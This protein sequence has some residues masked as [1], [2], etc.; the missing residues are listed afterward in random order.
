MSIALKKFNELD[1]ST[2]INILINC[3]PL[4]SKFVEEELKT[5]DI[6]DISK[7]PNIW[8][9]TR[10]QN[11][12][13]LFT[14]IDKNNIEYTNKIVELAINKYKPIYIST[15]TY[16]DSLNNLLNKYNYEFINKF[17]TLHVYKI[18]KGG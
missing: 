12:C 17:Y 6:I 13:N 9:H 1:N 15:I 11:N 4:E 10:L 8:I 14:S 18:Q 5:I 2:R 7:N 3:E 16:N